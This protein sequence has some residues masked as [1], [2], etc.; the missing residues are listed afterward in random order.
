MHMLCGKLSQGGARLC[1]S[2]DRSQSLMIINERTSILSDGRLVKWPSNLYNKVKG[3]SSGWCS[4]PRLWDPWWVA[5]VYRGPVW[6]PGSWAPGRF[7]V[8]AIQIAVLRDRNTHSLLRT[9]LYMQGLSLEPLFSVWIWS[10]GRSPWTS[11]NFS[12]SEP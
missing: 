8:W 9:I 6:G 1:W 10:R 2:S 5:G 7:R 12:N 4:A 3:L 11:S